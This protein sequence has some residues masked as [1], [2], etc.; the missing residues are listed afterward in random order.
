MRTFALLLKLAAP[1]FLLVAALHLV[2]GLQAEVLLGA[3]LPAQVLADPA[4]DSQ[5]RFYG[6]AFSVYG[7]LF[8]LCARNP[9]QHAAIIYA[10][11]AVFLASGMARLVAIAVHGIPPPLVLLL[12]SL[13][14]LLPP[15]LLLWFR[16]LLART[17]D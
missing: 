3:Q 13:E 12:M 16:H 1:L 14:L 9:R 2:L 11:L 4:L 15:P 17:N 7:V 8:W 10:L 5:N 6:V